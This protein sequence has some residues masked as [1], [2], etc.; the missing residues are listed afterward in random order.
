MDIKKLLDVAGPV[1]HEERVATLMKQA[2]E[3]KGLSVE[4]DKFG[5]VIAGRG[6]V[7]FGAHMDEI[8]L[9]ISYITEKGFLKF[10]RLGGIDPRV[11]VSQRVLLMGEKEDIQGVVGSKPPHLMEREEMEK[12]HKIK[13]LFI[14]IGASS[15]EEVEKMGIKPGTP[16]VFDAPAFKNG[17]MWFGKAVDNRAGC[18]LLTLLAGEVDALLVGT[19]QEEVSWSGKGATIFAR[20][21]QPEYFVAVD[22]AIAG[23]QPGIKEEEAP[24]KIGGGPVIVPVEAGG[25]GNY[26]PPALY[27]KVLKIAEDENIPY[28]IEVLEHGATDAASVHNVGYGIPSISIS[29][30]S[31]YIHSSVSAFSEKDID[32]TVK[33]LKALAREL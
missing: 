25:V 21:Y 22:V 26:T 12:A 4:R 19:T 13:D 31:R 32:A 9:M 8:G 30:P 24:I 1:G 2:F 23:D 20:K 33:L 7:A 11:L 29:I 6:K 5:N 27:K 28:Q 3:E 15:K 16:A 18:Y 10:I 17:S 14:D